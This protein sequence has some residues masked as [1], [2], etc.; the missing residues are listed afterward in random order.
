MEKNK[1]QLLSGLVLIVISVILMFFAFYAHFTGLSAVAAGASQPLGAAISNLC[2][3]I[4]I[5][6]IGLIIIGILVVLHSRSD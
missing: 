3:G 2:F 6:S 5:L 4:V 1:L